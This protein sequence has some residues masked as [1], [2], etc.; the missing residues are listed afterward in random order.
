MNCGAKDQWEEVRLSDKKG[1]F[2]AYSMDYSS[3]P[4]DVPAIT[5]IVNFEGGGRMQCLLTDREVEE[6][7]VDMPVEMSFRKLEFRDGIHNYCW[8][9]V[10]ARRD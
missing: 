1:T 10:P 5:A 7:R 8:K 6:V 9:C 3:A 4:P 2:F